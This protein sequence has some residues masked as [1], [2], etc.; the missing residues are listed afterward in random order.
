MTHEYTVTAMMRTPLVRND[1]ELTRRSGRTTR[2]E[3]TAKGQSEEENGIY[4]TIRQCH[5]DRWQEKG[6]QVLDS[7]Y[8]WREANQVQ[9]NPAPSS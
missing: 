7:W 9:M 6:M 2:E 5:N 3:E 8:E 1:H 4:T